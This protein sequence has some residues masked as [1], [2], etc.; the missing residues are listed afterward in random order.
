M[1]DNWYSL[2]ELAQYSGVEA[3]TIRSWI[4]QGLLP[5]PDA[6]GRAAAYPA[7]TLTR[8]LAVKAMREH[9]GMPLQAIRQELLLADEGR[10]AAY[11]ATAG[12]GVE[13]RLDPSGN[14]TASE[15]APFGSTAA[16]YLQALRNTGVFR[17]GSP[18]HSPSP[19]LPVRPNPSSRLETQM[20][21]A[22][23]QMSEP[24]ASLSAPPD[25]V[26]SSAKSA[27]SSSPMDRL[28]VQLQRAL[29]ERTVQRKARGDI[30]LAIPITPDI[31]LVVRG[32]L[33]PEEV[34]LLERIADTLRELLTGG[35]E[36]E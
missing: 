10:I 2:Q 36:R 33:K 1:E 11:A 15:D 9:Y 14:G 4:Q 35:P 28:A 6:R 5:G 32:S 30:R 19:N 18:A 12:A 31:E 7:S 29:G 21:A 3:R 25:L 20:P 8:L 27:A 17:G 13:P 22:P 34:A 26:D 23:R 24:A 16:D